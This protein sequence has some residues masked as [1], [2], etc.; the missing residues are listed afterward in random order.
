MASTRFSF[1]LCPNTA[2]VTWAMLSF[3]CSSQFMA[4]AASAADKAPSILLPHGWTF[5]KISGWL[6]FCY[7]YSL[8]ESRKITD[9]QF[10]QFFLLILL[11]D[12]HDDFKTFTCQSWWS[13]SPDF[14]IAIWTHFYAMTLILAL[15][16]HLCKL[17]S[18]P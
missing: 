11:P 10:V 3:R 9:F 13:F 2:S 16:K 1:S 8:K 15:E 12:A 6:F 5:L 14:Y 4:P 17:H 7:L 18:S